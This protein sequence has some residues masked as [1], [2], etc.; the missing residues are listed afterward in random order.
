MRAVVGKKRWLKRPAASGA[1]AFACWMWPAAADAQNLRLASGFEY[2]R[3]LYGSFAETEIAM[4]SISAR[5]SVNGWTYSLTVPYVRVTGPGAPF[6]PQATPVFA[7]RLPEGVD[8][9]AIPLV[10]LPDDPSFLFPRLNPTTKGFGD[11]TAGVGRSL[12]L[13]R[14]RLYLDAMVLAKLPVGDV[15]KLIGT[16]RTDITMQAD[17]IYET[18][19]FGFVIGGGRT[20][21]GKTPRFELQDR[22]RLSAAAY[23]PVGRRFTVGALY[24]WREPVLVGSDDISEVTTYVSARI[25]SRL[26]VLAYSV[27]GLSDASPDIGAGIRF[28]IDFDVGGNPNRD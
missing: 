20:F 1:L 17:F 8:A 14:D 28:S 16:G 18:R 9:A 27:T 7:L 11:V 4:A 6:N 23:A 25:N 24:D 26:S 15:D 13:K 2:T 21:V 5:Y 3:G 10:S 19:R 22:W 12:E